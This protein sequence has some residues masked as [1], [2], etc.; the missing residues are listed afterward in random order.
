LFRG[1]SCSETQLYTGPTRQGHPRS[2]ANTLR[3][4]QRPEAAA[5]SAF[6]RTCGPSES[7]KNEPQIAAGKARRSSCGWPD[8]RAFWAKYL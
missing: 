1:S 2:R 5:I 4:L 8:G 3:L 6:C 7:H